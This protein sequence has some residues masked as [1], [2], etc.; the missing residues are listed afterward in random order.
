MAAG[1]GGPPPSSVPTS[2]SRV[3]NELLDDLDDLDTAQPVALDMVAPADTESS[4]TE[5]GLAD[6]EKKSRWLGRRGSDQTKQQQQLPS[7]VDPTDEAEAAGDVAARSRVATAAA[8]ARVAAT[9][10]KEA[11]SK[12]KEAAKGVR[13]ET[14]LAVKAAAAAATAAAAAAKNPE[15]KETVEPEEGDNGGGEASASAAAG[16]QLDRSASISERAS[17]LS[18]AVSQ[19]GTAVVYAAQTSRVSR[20]RGSSVLVQRSATA[21][22]GIDL[23]KSGSVAIKYSK[24]GKARPTKFTL[25]ADEATLAWE[26]RTAGTR[27]LTPSGLARSVRARLGTARQVLIADVLDISVG[28]QSD[29][30]RRH[31]DWQQSRQM[32]QAKSSSDAPQSQPIESDSAEADALTTHSHL[33]LSIVLMGALPPRPDEI[34]DEVD[35][36]EAAASLGQRATLDVQ[37]ESEETLGYWVAALRELL[38]EGQQRPAA[39]PTP[40]APLHASAGTALRRAAPVDATLYEKGRDAALLALDM[41]AGTH[42][43]VALT[44]L[45]AL[46]VVVF[47]VLYF[48][49]LV[50]WHGFP[51]LPPLPP[52]PVAADNATVAANVTTAANT[53]ATSNAT[54]MADAQEAAAAVDT[55]TSE[56]DH[57]AN[58]CIQILTA[59]FTYISFFTLPWRVANAVH[60]LGRRRSCEA[61]LDF[62]GRP[63]KGI[64]FH[65][66]PR[67]RC[68]IVALLCGN[69]LMQ[70]AT[71]LCRFAWSS[72]RSSQV[73]VS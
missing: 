51:P 69:F 72:Y 21:V 57:L 65:L 23:L 18:R 33:F 19:F 64:W 38:N 68:C 49:L 12:T 7:P 28:A 15:A 13:H 71:Q 14:A 40:F 3:R 39:Y 24:H 45:W 62:Y 58:I 59:L 54:A 55:R 8:V 70:Y 6:K 66:P 73:M 9:K 2:P 11:A 30:Y 35:V 50:G 29:V 53:T 1:D 27:S 46:A 16:E 17:R 41:Y 10:T 47:G 61:G 43:F 52:L 22:V 37:F 26:G 56:A 48:F 60:L 20:F 63:T 44:A 42:L 32:A 34:D 31:M 25:S 36:A 4:W 5:I 67:K